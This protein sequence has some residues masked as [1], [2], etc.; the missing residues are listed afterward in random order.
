M[1]II[2]GS[3]QGLTANG[4]Q[5]LDQDTPGV[6]EVA[7]VGDLFGWAVT[8]GRFRGAK[9]ADLAVGAPFDGVVSN[10]DG[11]GVVNVLRGSPGGITTSGNRL[12]AQGSGG[13]AGTP[14]PNEYF[15]WPAALRPEVDRGQRLAAE[16]GPLGLLAEARVGI[17]KP[18]RRR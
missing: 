7:E 12:L 18:T 8:A 17:G 16:S 13:L 4:A 14:E 1:N 6:K 15:S 9:V 10:G 2:Y 5:P 11:A 3:T